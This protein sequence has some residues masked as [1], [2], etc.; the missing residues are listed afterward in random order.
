[1]EFVYEK[2]ITPIKP[3]DNDKYWPGS[4]YSMFRCVLKRDDRY[5]TY[6]RVCINNKTMLMY[7][8]F[9][10]NWES[11]EDKRYLGSDIN[12]QDPRII[13]VQDKIYDTFIEKYSEAVK[14]QKLGSGL[15]KGVIV[16]PMIEEKAIASVEDVVAD[17]LSKGVHDKACPPP[18]ARPSTA[19][20]AMSLPA[21]PRV[22]TLA[23]FLVYSP[24]ISS[25]TES[26]TT[27]QLSTATSA[28][29]EAIMAKMGLRA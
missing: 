4:T 24:V 18:P 26:Q 21:P 7:E 5:I 15:E 8:S 6:V 16:G 25:C 14:S 10:L 28:K 2:D 19:D 17:A 9:N 1:M 11:N 22:T 13:E 27:Q 29:H 23:S 3:L 20:A 12:A